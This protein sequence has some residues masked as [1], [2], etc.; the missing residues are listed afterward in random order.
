MPTT[1]ELPTA[2][3]AAPEGTSRG[4]LKPYSVRIYRDDRCRMLT[5][6][7]A[8]FIYLQIASQRYI[9]HNQVQ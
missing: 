2:L 3:E 6:Q 9:T 4:Q 8:G 1:P 7:E 5:L